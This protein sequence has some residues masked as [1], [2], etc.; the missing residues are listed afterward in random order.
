MNITRT[1]IGV[2]MSGALLSTAACGDLQGGQPS[3]APERSEEGPSA[4]TSVPSTTS[5]SSLE[6]QTTESSPPEAKTTGAETPKT[7]QAER[8]Q[9]EVV[10]VKIR[11]LQYIR[12]PVTV[13][14]GTTVRWVN[15]DVADHTVT[16]EDPGGPLRSEAFGQGG[17][18]KHRFREVGEFAYYCEI[19][20]S[21]KASVIVK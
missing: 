19:H 13:A 21:M 6:A 17:S 3:Q 15:E 9:E 18:F 7:A 16:S 10:V 12:S 8:T 4:T 20:P 5:S 1:I 14:A 11:G 2:M